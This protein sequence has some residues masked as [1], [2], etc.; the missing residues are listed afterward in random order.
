MLVLKIKGKKLHI[1]SSQ[2]YLPATLLFRRYDYLAQQESR[3]NCIQTTEI[4]PEGRLSLQLT[5]NLHFL[6]LSAPCCKGSRGIKNK[7]RR[8]RAGICIYN[9]PLCCCRATGAGAGP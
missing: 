3:L 9:I 7:S 1:F 4:I 6:L 8:N 2:K 5:A